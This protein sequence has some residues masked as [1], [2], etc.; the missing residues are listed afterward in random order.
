MHY[1]Y[2]LVLMVKYDNKAYL[3]IVPLLDYL[4]PL[5]SA[6]PLT[7]QFQESLGCNLAE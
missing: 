5:P 7:K 3:Y 1:Y 2:K 6:Q 4:I